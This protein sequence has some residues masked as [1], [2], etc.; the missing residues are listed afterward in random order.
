[1]HEGKLMP[2]ELTYQLE[3]EE[4]KVT[5][6]TTKVLDYKRS[7]FELLR[8][9]WPTR[10]P[11]IHQAQVPGHEPADGQYDWVELYLDVFGHD[12]RGKTRDKLQ[13]LFLDTGDNSVV[14]RFGRQV[15]LG[16]GLQSLFWRRTLHDRLDH[17]L[18][19]LGGLQQGG[20]SDEA[21]LQEAKELIEGVVRDIAIALTGQR[22]DFSSGQVKEETGLPFPPEAAP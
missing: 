19:T 1:L 6:T 20:P 17:A 5:H 14:R 2:S 12:N 16:L 4:I 11:S 13:G 15:P 9:A 7:F 10:W 22:I 3:P 21:E 8:A 18:N